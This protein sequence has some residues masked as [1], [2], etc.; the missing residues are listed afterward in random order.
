MPSFDVR[1]LK[2]HIIDISCEVEYCIIRSATRGGISHDC[3]GHP[4]TVCNRLHGVYQGAAGGPLDI[5]HHNTPFAD[6]LAHDISGYPHR[7]GHFP[8]QRM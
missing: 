8:A 6:D 4:Q 3:D 5:L 1:K 2:N 7:Q